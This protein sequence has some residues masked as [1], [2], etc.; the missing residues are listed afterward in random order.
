MSLMDKFSDPS[1]F[2]SLGFGDKMMGSLITMIM[3][4]GITFCV[5]LLLWGFVAIMGRCIS[6]V[7]K[8]KKVQ[9]TP[10]ADATPS[11]AAVPV[12]SVSND[13]ITVAVI[14]AALEAYR[15]DGGTGSLIVRKITR[16]PG[17]STPWSNAAIDDCIESRRF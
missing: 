2:D 3:G 6:S 10:A 17:E 12:V 9:E 13:D 8:S 7:G 16:I 1:L 5:L 15:A 4:M 11:R 14:A